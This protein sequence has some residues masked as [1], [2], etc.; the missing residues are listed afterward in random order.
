MKANL[1]GLYVIT[2][3]KLISRDR[4]VETVEQS[5]KGGAGIVQLREKDTPVYQ[6]IEIGIEL[7]KVT[8]R[9]NVPL[10]INDSPELAKEIGAD[11]VH[12]GGDDKSIKEAR[13][14]LGDNSIIGATCYNEIERGLDAV[15]N[16][17]DYVAFGTPYYTPTKPERQPTSIETL[18]QAVKLI[19]E[20]PIFAIG[21]ITRENARPILGTGVDGIA[22]ITSIYGSPDP[23]NAARELAQL[24]S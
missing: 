6:I 4:F 2:D 1:K 21:G 19:T 22:V 13:K 11:G 3:K 24:C 17:A 15:G 5:I 20:I 7:L 8:K 10:I 23:E 9:Y 12:L 18:I 16:G 14:I